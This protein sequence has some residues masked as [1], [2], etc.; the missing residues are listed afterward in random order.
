[1]CKNKLI[2]GEMTL[3]RI[4]MIPCDMFWRTHLRNIRSIDLLGSSRGIVDSHGD[5][6]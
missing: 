4:L 2:M 3:R 5:A 6:I 1:M